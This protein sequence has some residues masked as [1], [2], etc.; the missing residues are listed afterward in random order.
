MTGDLFGGDDH[1][2]RQEWTGMPEFVQENK[3]PFQKIVVNFENAAD[4]QKF[5]SLVGYKLTDKSRSI[6]FPHRDRKNRK[7]FVYE[8]GDCATP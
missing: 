4:V 2:W 8:D 3:E 7:A 6:W 1:D 5:A